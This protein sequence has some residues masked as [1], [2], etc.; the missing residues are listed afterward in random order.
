[1]VL[2]GFIFLVYALLLQVTL[3]VCHRE[4]RHTHVHQNLLRRR[5]QPSSNMAASVLD[6][7]QAYAG[8]VLVLCRTST[9]V[10]V[11]G[12]ANACQRDPVLG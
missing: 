8:S 5:L 2:S 4:L 3:H 6:A 9:M 7:R 11:A 10:C 12:H 1:M